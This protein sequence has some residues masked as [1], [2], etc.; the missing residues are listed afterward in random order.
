ML[1]IFPWSCTLGRLIIAIGATD[2]HLLEE[3]WVVCVELLDAA[4]IVGSPANA[5]RDRLHVLV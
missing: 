1:V 3:T 2:W 5:E 4:E